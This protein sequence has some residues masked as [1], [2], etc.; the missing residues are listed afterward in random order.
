MSISREKILEQRKKLQRQREKDEA[1]LKA[2]QIKIKRSALKLAQ[3][4]K[5]E[6]AERKIVLGNFMLQKAKMDPSFKLWLEGEIGASN[7]G[8]YEKSLFGVFETGLS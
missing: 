7:L 4:E 3:A 8:I 5:K 6:E 2:L 1:K